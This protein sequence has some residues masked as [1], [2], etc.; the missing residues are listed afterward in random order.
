M[1]KYDYDGK[2]CL[3]KLL[4]SS[5]ASKWVIIPCL[6]NFLHTNISRSDRNESM[7]RKIEILSIESLQKQKQSIW[8]FFFLASHYCHLQA[9]HT[10][11]S[12]EEN[13]YICFVFFVC[14][15][16]KI[17]RLPNDTC[18][19]SFVFI[20]L[21]FYGLHQHV[22]H[23]FMY[24]VRCISGKVRRKLDSKVVLIH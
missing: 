4:I 19:G 18:F 6:Y 17:R 23:S 22:S 1:W 14:Q 5:S 16:S 8:R 9:S 10:Q 24:S 3:L 21:H 7:K 15:K 11:T 12:F 13:T 2:W 20:W